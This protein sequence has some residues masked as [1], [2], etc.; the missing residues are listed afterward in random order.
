MFKFFNGSN[1]FALKTYSYNSWLHMWIFM[2]N[3]NKYFN[4]FVNKLVMLVVLEM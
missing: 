3:I 4:Q 1:R 2:E